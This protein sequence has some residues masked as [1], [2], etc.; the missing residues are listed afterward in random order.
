MA[1]KST[2]DQTNVLL[3]SDSCLWNQVMISERLYNRREYYFAIMMERSANGP[4]I[5]ASSQGGVNIEEVECNLFM[6]IDKKNRERLLLVYY[7]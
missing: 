3:I 6:F 5:V 7:T 2:D 4:I 1:H